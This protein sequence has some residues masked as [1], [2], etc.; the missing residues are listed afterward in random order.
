TTGTLPAGKAAAGDGARL[1]QPSPAS[2]PTSRERRLRAG[3]LR[4]GKG[5]TTALQVSGNGR[6]TGRRSESIYPRSSTPSMRS[7]GAAARW[8]SGRKASSG[9]HRCAFCEVPVNSA[10]WTR[11]PKQGGY[12]DAIPHTP[13]PPRYAMNTRLGITFLALAAGACAA[14]LGARP[15]A[16][17]DADGPPAR[18]VVSFQQGVSGYEGTID[19]ELWAV[20]PNQILEKNDSAS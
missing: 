1:A 12:H 3:A 7:H 2:P 15:A 6:S 20:S 16:K 17:D 9:Q 18:Q 10:D 19:T 14:V 11:N 8:G 5:L 13:T 4:G